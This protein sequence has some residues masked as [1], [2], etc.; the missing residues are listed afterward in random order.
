MKEQASSASGSGAG[1]ETGPDVGPG[2]GS[3]TESH[4]RASTGPT[5]VT[6][7]PPCVA[8]AERDQERV[9]WLRSCLAAAG[10]GPV[11]GSVPGSEG[12]DAVDVLAVTSAA[13]LAAALD[14]GGIDAV[15]V[16]LEID[17]ATPEQL[18][19][20]LIGDLD[21][22]PDAEPGAAPDAGPGIG[23]DAAA[24]PVFALA[25][26]RIAPPIDVPGLF[27]HIDRRLAPEHVRRVVASALARPTGS[28]SD[29]DSTEA[30]TALSFVLDAARQFAAQSDLSE[31]AEKLERAM[32]RIAG[33]D[34]A[35][36]L[37]HDPDDGSLWSETQH[38][39]HTEGSVASSGLAGFAAR[40]GSP[41]TVD[42]AA[43]DPRYDR[44]VDDPPGKGHEAIMVRPIMS[45]DGTIHA[46]L[47][48]VREGG[49]FPPLTRRSF[50]ALAEHVGPLMHQM[51]LRVEADAV[52]E[53]E[54]GDEGINDLFRAEALE[55]YL[56]R[57]K[58]GDVVR[59]SPTWVRWIYWPLL[60]LLVA[61]GVFLVVGRVD[62]YST[63]PAVVRT[64]ERSEVNAS[65]SGTVVEV[66]VETGQRVQRGQILARLHDAGEADEL[67]RLE[68]ELHTQLRNR[69]LDPSD[70]AAAAA[71]RSLRSSVESARSRLERRI[72]RAPRG[73]AVS[74][75]RIRVGQH[76][77]L[78]DLVVSL[79]EDS[80]HLKVVAF[81]PGADRPQLEPGM[82]LR[83]E[84]V[85]YRYAYQLVA[86]ESV[87]DEV[88]G[89]GEARRYLGGRIADGIVINGPVVVVEASLPTATF[90]ADDKLYEY[91]DG[92][93][94]LAEAKV[95]SRRIIEALIPQLERL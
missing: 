95:R 70:A 82:I 15:I 38:G 21:A 34:R 52:I 27:Y 23:P 26:Q 16:G 78:G 17:D 48:A 24:V 64:S 87:G 81:L 4:S 37:F 6:R 14:A 22:E 29:L 13:A 9:T 65:V 61:A 2:T 94:G 20:R 30:A 59:V 55:A 93:L 67:A 69:L 74:D 7:R 66:E 11:S 84:L 44:A 89:P 47:I 54:R 32:L 25:D 85:G 33:A 39:G 62:Q 92:M 88:I 40:T 63:G 35:S 46:I 5:L 31:A 90:E 1:P 71:V 45:D 72:I 10:E 12:Q 76:L 58:Q 80:T 3:A 36:C 86:I 19:A 50:S 91:H 18:A 51:A 28:A 41:V 42:R 43:D 56:S 8:V 60:A 53:Q 77:N 49:P 75:V 73:G 68:H 57:G 79:L 83:L